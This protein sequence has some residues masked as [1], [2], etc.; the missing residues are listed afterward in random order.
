MLTKKNCLEITW[1]PMTAASYDHQNPIA[2]FKD[3][4]WKVSSIL[5]IAVRESNY[6]I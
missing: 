3:Y 5:Y 2:L 6:S 4:T 1:L